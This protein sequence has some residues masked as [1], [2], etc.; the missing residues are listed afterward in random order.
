MYMESKESR[1]KRGASWEVPQ[2][3]K[4]RAAQLWDV[5]GS[6]EPLLMLYQ[7]GRFQA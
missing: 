6:P 7:N 3:T 4:P 2:Q 5:S 1:V